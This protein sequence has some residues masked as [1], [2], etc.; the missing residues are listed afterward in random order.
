MCALTWPRSI[1]LHKISVQHTKEEAVGG[2]TSGLIGP[3]QKV[4]WQTKH[5]GIRQTLETKISKYTRPFFF[6]DEMVSGNFR[7]YD[8]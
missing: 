7:N 5:L 2:I 1:D 8:S 3:N 6:T 4:L